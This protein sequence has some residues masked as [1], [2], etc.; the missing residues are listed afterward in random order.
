MGIHHY[1]VTGGDGGKSNRAATVM[2]V[3]AVL[4]SSAAFALTLMR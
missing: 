2:S 4:L 3:I 1:N